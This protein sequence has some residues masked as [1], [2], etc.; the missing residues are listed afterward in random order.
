MRSSSSGGET[1]RMNSLIN[2]TSTSRIKHNS[3]ELVSQMLRN[4]RTIPNRTHCIQSGICPLN[5]S[6]P[7]R[8]YNNDNPL[9]PPALLIFC[10][11]AKLDCLRD[12]W[13]VLLF[14]ILSCNGKQEQTHQ[15][16][17]YADP[18][19]YKIHSQNTHCTA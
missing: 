8:R 9:N 13:C 7:G 4:C 18:C 15:L 5:I 2:L 16:Y 10:S 14:G 1:E 19:L 17:E 6:N 11:I 3:P 12:I